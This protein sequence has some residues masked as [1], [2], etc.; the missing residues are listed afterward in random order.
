[1]SVGCLAMVPSRTAGVMFTEDPPS[2]QDGSIVIDAAWG[3]GPTVVEGTLVPDRF[4]RLKEP[5]ITI[6]EEHVSPKTFRLSAPGEAG[7]VKEAVPE[8]ENRQPALTWEE[9]MLLGRYGLQLEEYFGE[10]QDVE[11]AV[12]YKGQGPYLQSPAPTRRPGPRSPRSP[13]PGSR[14]TRC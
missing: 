9:I 1:M 12:D 14:I 5:E 7:L 13:R 2:S 10:P 11:F 3:L 8:A 4:V 6:I